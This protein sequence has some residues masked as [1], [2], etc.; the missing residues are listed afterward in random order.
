MH[1]SWPSSPMSYWAGSVTRFWEEMRVKQEASVRSGASQE[2]WVTVMVDGNWHIHPLLRSPCSSVHETFWH[3]CGYFCWQMEPLKKIILETKSETVM[4]EI[5][6]YTFT[7]SPNGNAQGKHFGNYIRN[8]HGWETNAC[9][10]TSSL[11]VGFG[12]QTLHTWNFWTQSRKLHH[13]IRN[14]HGWDRNWHIH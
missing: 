8:C 1:N 11:R 7:R 5:K 9:F 2:I 13:D 14:C 10:F 3:K 6:I 12:L 4:L